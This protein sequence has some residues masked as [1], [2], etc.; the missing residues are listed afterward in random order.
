[1]TGARIVL[2]ALALVA[3]YRAAASA[4]PEDAP[5]V[6]DI[7]ANLDWA[8]DTSQG[9]WCTSSRPFPWAG[10]DAV[11]LEGWFKPAAAPGDRPA[12]L[13]DVWDTTRQQSWAGLT[14]DAGGHLRARPEAPALSAAPGVWT[15]VALVIRRGSAALITWDAS[16]GT[17]RVEFE[18][19]WP[20][21]PAGGVQVCLG[22]TP[23]GGPWFDGLVDEVR[24]WTTALSETDLDAW[25]H[26]RVTDAH[27]ARRTLA[28][29]WPLDAGHGG[30]AA[31]GTG[32]APLL[33]ADPRWTA[34]PRLD[35]G[36][37]LRAV[38]GRSA[39]FL[40]H[41]RD[42]TGAERAWEARVEIGRSS[43][44]RS[45]PPTRTAA[46]VADAAHDH[47]AHVEWTGLEPQTRYFYVPLIDGRRG[48]DPG[49]GGFPS[50]VTWPDLG[51]R[52]ADFSGAFF[53]DQHVG[54]GAPPRLDAYA[55]AA[56]AQPTF[57]AQLGDVA[58]GNLDGITR[59]NSR[60]AAHLQGIW[61]RNYR[62]GTPQAAFAG[63]VSLALATISDHEIY[64]NYSLNWHARGLGTS[65][66]D[67]DAT[68][69]DRVRQYDSSMA[70]WWSYFGWGDR[71]DDRLG[72][73]ARTDHG[74][75]V[76]AERPV[77]AVA[78]AGDPRVCVARGAEVAAGDFVWLADARE[79]VLLA[80]ARAGG[81]H[82]GCP[83]GS[84]T[85]DRAPARAYRAEDGAV[86]GVGARYERPALY[87]AW[88]PYPF[89]EFFV[90]DTT[91][92]RGDP[93]QVK[94]LYAVEANRDTDH[95]RYRWSPAEGATYIHGDRA[96]G[97]NRTTDAVRSW[98]GPTQRAALLDAVGSSSARLIVV[99]AGYPLYSVKFE[100]SPRYWEGREAGFDYAAEVEQVMAA[101]ERL[102]RLVLWVH[103]DGHSPALVRL[104]RNIY[105]LQIG[106]TL[107]S[108]GRPG[109]RSRRLVSGTR[110]TR[111]T[112]GGGYL[113]AGHQPD[114]D[115]ESEE[116]DVFEARLDQ[117]VGHLRLYFHPG[118]EALRSSET[119]GLRRGASA[120][121]VVMFARQDPAVGQTARQVVGKVVRLRVGERFRHSVVSA[122]RYEPGQA[123]LTLA[124]PIVEDAPDELRL[125]L[126]A[127]PWV[128]ARWFDARGREW[129]DFAFVMRKD[130]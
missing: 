81:P 4:P 119:A 12:P 95:S 28:A 61:E 129:R 37:V 75:S 47:V 24:A 38:D 94:Q 41:A 17:R 102:D 65:R 83:E 52:N 87:R 60:T 121:E 84:V 42:V 9:A 124:D 58:T 68:L 29:Y 79:G 130:L 107:P 63:N 49:P 100:G 82:P 73:V 15:H 8:V 71:F 33:A 80:Q 115:R 126:D 44:L 22:G 18:G 118:Q 16:A 35:Y 43:D 114:L 88:Q 34:L 30:S 96:H 85:L 23:A 106:A 51:G 6:A 117:F 113:I 76:M 78:R 11:T 10:A 19:A 123:I 72:R 99:V 70:R 105:Q 56:E 112:I 27:P 120:R 59:E 67:P 91:S 110:S 20:A 128:E 89:V 26:R 74:E 57:W 55:A 1:V 111:D 125:L 69:H 32:G 108:S 97:A 98:L 21:D 90:A 13:V 66:E 109:H 64:D 86:L 93:Y 25:R 40:F 127:E 31:D 62:P 7:G 104:R 48:L 39:R 36:P 50:F 14:L 101:L 2:A 3:A 122:Y 54:G 116:D 103:G 46:S 92:F 77:P 53:A 5:A 45:V